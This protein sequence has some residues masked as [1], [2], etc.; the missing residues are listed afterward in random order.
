M[1]QFDVVA[2]ASRLDRSRGSRKARVNINL[3]SEL[4][5]GSRRTPGGG[6]L[7]WGAA[8][9]K[10]AEKNRGR[11]IA[12]K[13]LEANIMDKDN[14]LVFAAGSLYLNTRLQSL[15]G[16]KRLLRAGLPA[17]PNLPLLEMSKCHRLKQEHVQFILLRRG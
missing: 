15:L 12:A 6:T 16:L 4:K 3:I 9:V 5:K 1:G 7:T 8:F 2:A 14:S 13:A 17:S 10:R 11:V